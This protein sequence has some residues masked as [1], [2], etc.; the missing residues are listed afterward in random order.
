[1]PREKSETLRV[2]RCFGCYAFFD[3][4]ER[5]LRSARGGIKWLVAGGIPNSLS[6]DLFYGFPARL[7]ILPIFSAYLL[8]LYLFVL[9]CFVFS[10]KAV[11]VLFYFCFLYSLV[12]AL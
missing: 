2:L 6:S 7:C 5:Y 4:N 1:M 11:S 10:F 3:E 9:F 12:G 8:L